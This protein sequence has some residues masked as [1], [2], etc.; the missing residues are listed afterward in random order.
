MTGR[1]RTVQSP[2][3][4]DIDARLPDL[5]LLAAG[6]RALH[7]AEL[8]KAE[9]LGELGVEP[10]LG[11]SGIDEEIDLVAAVYPHA[12]DRQRRGFQEFEARGLPVPVHLIGRLALEALQLGD[13]QV[14]Y[15]SMISLLLP[16][17][18]PLSAAA[19]F[20]KSSRR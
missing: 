9:L 16:T 5:G 1:L 6:E 3:L 7:V 17:S 19:A 13:V 18:T 10:E 12:D 14:G 2:S 11:A 15:C 20:W 8:R 4:S